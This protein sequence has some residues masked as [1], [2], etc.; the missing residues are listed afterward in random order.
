MSKITSVTLTDETVAQIEKLKEMER[1]SMAGIINEAVRYY[2]QY[3]LK[4]RAQ[5]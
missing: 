4:L 2:F 5:E 3:I 1:R